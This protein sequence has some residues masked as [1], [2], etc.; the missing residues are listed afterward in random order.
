M[1]GHGE[2]AGAVVPAL[3]TASI[4]AILPQIRQ[5]ESDGS[6]AG[7]LAPSIDGLKTLAWWKPRVDG[8]LLGLGNR[9]FRDPSG[10]PDQTAE[11]CAIR[12]CDC[13]IGVEVEDAHKSL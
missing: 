13:S 5:L 11:A 8:G 1:D 6:E 12:H 4:E 10:K 2:G 9:V 3:A 7:G